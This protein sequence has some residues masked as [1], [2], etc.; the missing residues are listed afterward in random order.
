MVL[1]YSFCCYVIAGD[2]IKISEDIDEL[3]QHVDQ[4]EMAFVVQRYVD[5]PFLLEGGRKF[6][7]R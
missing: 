5:Q 7:I 2:G 1:F 6:D 4:V 3:L